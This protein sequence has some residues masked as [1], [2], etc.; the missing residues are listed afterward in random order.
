MRCL[1]IEV[2]CKPN[3]LQIVITEPQTKYT[4][5]Y[6]ITPND[7]ANDLLAHVISMSR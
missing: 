4:R 2:K 3:I 7:F 1:V 5:L 6:H